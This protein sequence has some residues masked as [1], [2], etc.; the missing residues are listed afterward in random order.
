[1]SQSDEANRPVW[2]GRFAC[3]F[4]L[5]GVALSLYVFMADAIHAVDKSET[6]LRNLLPVSFNWP[7]FSAALLLLAVPIVDV[8]RGVWRRRRASQNKPC[9][10]LITGRCCRRACLPLDWPGAIPRRCAFWISRLFGFHWRCWCG[11]RRACSLLPSGRRSICAAFWK[12]PG[13]RWLA[14]L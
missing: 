3:G 5:T 6:A 11:G 14:F 12:Q 7:M 4:G 13:T 2:P 8:C 9:R 10:S 1:V